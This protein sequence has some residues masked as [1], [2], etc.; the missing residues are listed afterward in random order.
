[1]PFIFVIGLPGSGKTTYL[2]E[3]QKQY[4]QAVIFDDTFGFSN[5]RKLEIVG[6]DN[7]VIISD[8]RLTNPNTFKIYAKI[9]PD[10]RAVYLFENDVNN[11]IHN[12]IHRCKS[13][14]NPVVIKN[15]V[16]VLKQELLIIDI[17]NMSKSYTLESYAADNFDE[18]KTVVWTLH[19][20]SVIKAK[21]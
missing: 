12:V 1:M 6:R 4:N 8:P 19:Q 20:L 3:L 16:Q 17:K 13:E 10:I 18:R 2:T 21:Q 9:L 11:C 14:G 5:I 15:N 7:L